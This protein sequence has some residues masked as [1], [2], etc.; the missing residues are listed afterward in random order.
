MSSIFGRLTECYAGSGVRGQGI[1]LKVFQICQMMQHSL[2]V[3]A[4]TRTYV[5]NMKS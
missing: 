3:T 2:L 1:E 5:A 4:A